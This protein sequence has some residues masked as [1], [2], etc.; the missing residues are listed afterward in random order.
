MTDRFSGFNDDFWEFFTDL[1][2][3]NNR[4]WFAGNKTRYQ[5]IVVS[6]ISNFIAAIGPRLHKISPHYN[7]DP[8]PNKGSMFRIYRDVRFSKNKQPYKEHAAA[9]F[10]HRLSKDAHA[11]GYYV[12][13][14]DGNIRFGGG[15]WTPP[16]DVLQKIRERIVERPEAWQAVIEDKDIIAQFSGIKGDGLKRPPRGFDIGAPHMNDLKRKSF[17]AIKSFTNTNITR[18]ANFADEVIEAF[19]AATPL[20]YFISDAVGAEF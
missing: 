13:L 1:K 7:A 11:P 10:R 16:S 12:H 9:Q 18:S 15:I 4:E 20:M 19:E 14:E 17:F 2:Q 5:E 3:N 8:R 6:P